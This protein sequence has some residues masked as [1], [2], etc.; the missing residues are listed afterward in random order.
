MKVIPVNGSTAVNGTQQMSLKDVLPEIA[1]TRLLSD[2]SENLPYFYT[3]S[4]VKLNRVNIAQGCYPK[5]LDEAWTKFDELKTSENDRP[6]KLLKSNQMYVVQELSN[7]G[8]ALEDYKLKNVDEAFSIFNQV[9][10]G[11]AVSESRYEFEH[12]DLH[13][14]NILIKNCSRENLTFELRGDKLI[15]PV[16]GVQ[17]TIID[18]SLSRALHNDEFTMQPWVLFQDLDNDQELF[19]GTGDIQFQV[20]RD[21]AAYFTKG[22]PNRW[23]DFRGKTNVLWLEY[24]HD[25]LV[26]MLPKK[27]KGRKKFVGW[28]GTLEGIYSTVEYF[29]DML[30]NYS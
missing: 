14:G 7:G 16:F 20:Y 21:M 24:L 3:E 19:E 2:L 10:L 8:V 5:V 22:I 18:F 27:C 26:E 13:I 4:F 30:P 12:R 17:A 15:L 1:I 9:A 25:K 28:K 11:L 23:R 6:S 29:Q